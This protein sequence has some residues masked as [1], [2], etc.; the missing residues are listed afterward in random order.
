M[1]LRG[2]RKEKKEEKLPSG[3]TADYS[4]NFFGDMSRNPLT[5]TTSV[6]GFNAVLTLDSPVDSFDSNLVCTNSTLQPTLTSQQLQQRALPLPPLPPRAPKKINTKTNFRHSLS[7]EAVD[8]KSSPEATSYHNL[9]SNSLRTNSS[10]AL[11]EDTVDFKANFNAESE[12]HL[13]PPPVYVSNYDKTSRKS[14]SIESLTDSTT[15]SSFATPPFSSSPVGEGQ[16]YYSRFATVLVNSSPDDA[17]SEFP[18]PDIEPAPL[19]KAR[20]VVINRRPPPKNDF[21]FSIRRVMTVCR[22]SGVCQLKSVI[23]A[24]MNTGDSNFDE[25][26]LLPGDQLLEVNGVSVE[27]KTREEIT[28]LIKSSDSSVKIKVKKSFA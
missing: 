5:Q 20:E 28:E 9:R 11:N 2:K 27:D 22:N 17:V 18:L 14:P 26:G 13:M 6:N 8:P 23:L 21:G 4:A 12:T 10:S 3:I 1:K 25:V 19:P 7:S 24:E 15:N 16:G